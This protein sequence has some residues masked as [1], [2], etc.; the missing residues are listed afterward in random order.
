MDPVW[1]KPASGKTAVVVV[2]ALRYDLGM[3]LKEL[4]GG[5]DVSLEARITSVPSITPVGMTAMLPLRGDTIAAVVS[6]GKLELEHEKY[7]DL[8]SRPNRTKLLTDRVSAEC[9]ELSDL[10]SAAESPSAKLLVVFTSEIDNLG[11]KTGHDLSKFLDQ[12]VGDLKI[13]VEKLH[14]NGYETVHIATDHGFILMAD[15]GDKIDAPKNQAAVGGDRYLF[16]ADGA[17]VDE[18]MLTLSMPMD[19]RLRLAFAPGIACFVKPKQYLHGGISLEEM[20][21]P[22]L[23]SV[24]KQ[25]S[26][27]MKV[28][29]ALPSPD[30]TTMSIK[31]VLVVEPPVASDLFNQ[32][33]GRNIAITFLRD[34]T[35]VALP[36]QVVIEP[37]TVESTQSVTVFLDENIGFRRDDMLTL[38]VRDTDTQEDLGQNKVAKVVRDLGG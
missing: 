20:V 6:S 30:V 28:Q 22:L 13:A 10:M 12:L 15:D 3:A 29:C 38:Q 35:E 24:A 25:K 16:L 9:I 32:P 2:D 19:E 34:G 8:T 18:S 33:L 7:G 1:K 11:H 5:S 31:V 17:V 4:I 21:V 36:K 23:T 26:E 37:G 14:A 27:K